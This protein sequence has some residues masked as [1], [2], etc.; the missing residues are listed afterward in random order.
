MNRT[1]GC[2]ETNVEINEKLI[3]TDNN[4]AC[5][6]H[7]QMIQTAEKADVINWN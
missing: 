5:V 7:P 4:E 6:L 1:F 3:K 2:M